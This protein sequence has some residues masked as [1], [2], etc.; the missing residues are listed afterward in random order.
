[1]PR[2]ILIDG[3]FDDW[4]R[5][6]PEYRDTIGDPVRRDYRGW[7]P[8]VRYVNRTGRN[9]IVEA[10]VSYDEENVY[11]YVR[12][13]GELTGGGDPNWMLLM[14]DSDSDGKT[15]W[16]G[17]DRIVNREPIQGGKTFIERNVDRGYSWGSPR[18]VALQ[19]G[20]SELELA[21]LARSDGYR[22]ESCRFR[23]QMGG[24]HSADGEWSDFT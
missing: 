19:I 21:V 15:G 23:L 3:R 4:K 9:D 22:Q 20:A 24:Q 6:E 10:K 2:P 7:N 1:M 11:F 8:G 17:Y 14:I 13:E 18:E 5:V 12:T 16:L